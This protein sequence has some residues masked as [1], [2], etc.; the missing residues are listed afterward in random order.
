MASTY[1]GNP[2]DSLKDYLRFM[3]GDTDMT[4]PL[5]TDEEYNY[6]IDNTTNVNAGSVQ[7]VLVFVRPSELWVL[8]LK[9]TQLA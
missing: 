7:C 6:I 4:Q 5:L 3:M 8:S 2:A 1:S 9:T